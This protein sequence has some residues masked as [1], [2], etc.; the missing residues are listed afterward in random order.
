MRCETKIENVVL[1]PFLQ[2][3]MTLGME[4]GQFH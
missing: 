1:F 3:S 4:E 2:A